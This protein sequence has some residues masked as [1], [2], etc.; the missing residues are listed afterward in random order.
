MKIEDGKIVWSKFDNFLRRLTDEVVIVW[1][2]LMFIINLIFAIRHDSTL[3]YFFAGIMLGGAIV[4]ALRLP[5]S[6][7]DER[8]RKSLWGIVH[9]Q[10]KLMGR[11]MKSR[12]EF[13]KLVDKKD[14][15]MK[16][17]TRRKK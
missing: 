14:D 5:L 3:S 17:K 2:C 6:K 1:W 4:M 13:V 12:E 16:K 10:D 8:N 9:D 11:M 15:I 7:S